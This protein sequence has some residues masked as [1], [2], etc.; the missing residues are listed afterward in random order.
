MRRYKRVAGQLSNTPHPTPPRKEADRL[1]WLRLIRSRRVS[2]ASF[3]RLLAEY[4]SAEAALLALPQIASQA[5]VTGYIACP[6]AVAQAEF[7]SAR[8]AG[9][10][11]LFFGDPHYPTLLADLADAPP[12][13][14]C[15]GDVSLLTRPMLAI[16]GARNASSLGLR[17]ARSLAQGL[18]EAGYVIVSGLA[19]GIDAQ[20]HQAALKGGTIAVLAGGAD[21]IYPAENKALAADIAQEGLLLSEQPPGLAPQTRHFPIRNRIISGL[22][23]GVTIIEAAARSGSLITARNALEQGR[24]V[25]AVPGHPFDSRASGCNMLIRDG[26]TLVRSPADIL[27]AMGLLPLAPPQTA[28]PQ[29]SPTIAPQAPCPIP[30]GPPQTRSLSQTAELHKQILNRLSPGPTPEDQLIRDLDMP[31]AILSSE[32]LALELDGQIQRHPGGLLSRD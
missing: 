26:A 12:I 28:S 27:D 32:L 31:P 9:L 5:G 22:C 3:H 29:V 16:V 18:S 10:K 24:D 15:R 25:M 1:S 21:V 14:W 6:E 4:G 23:R 11:P 13:L 2:P 7:S 8:N 30:A 19:R 20:T 17:M